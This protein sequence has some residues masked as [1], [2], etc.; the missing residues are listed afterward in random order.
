MPGFVDRAE[1]MRREGHIHEA[2]ETLGQFLK[3]RPNHPRALLLRSRLLYE[4]GSVPQAVEGLRDLGRIVTDREL[5]SIVAA[6]EQLRDGGKLWQAP[7]FATESMARLLAQQGYL[8]EALE[9]YRQLFQAAPERSE[10]CDEITRLKA[11]VERE[12]SREATKERVARE[13]EAWER[14]LQQH[15]RGS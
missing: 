1:T 4:L 14:W 2:L 7:A 15:Q 13:L 6:L 3:E 8:L 12:G 9:L 5:R 11:S 10:L